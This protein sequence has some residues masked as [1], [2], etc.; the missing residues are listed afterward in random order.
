MPYEITD[1]NSRVNFAGNKIAI[2][3]TK[4]YINK[5]PLYL[6]GEVDSRTNLNIK[7]RSNNLAIESLSKIFLPNNLPILKGDIDILAT[8]TGNLKTPKPKVRAAIRN[9]TAKDKKNSDLL[10]EFTKGIIDLAGSIDEPQGKIELIRVNILPKELYELIKPQKLNILITP[11]EIEFHNN[12]DNITTDKILFSGK[13][14]NYRKNPLEGIIKYRGNIDSNKIYTVAKKYNKRIQASAKG[15]IKVE[16]T[17]RIKGK[18][19]NIKTSCYADRW[20]YVSFMVIRELLNHP[21]VA[22]IDINTDGKDIIINNFTLNK[23]TESKEKIISINGKIKDIERPNLN[24]IR[25]IIPKNM[26]ISI[27]NLINSKITLKSDLTLDGNI[28]K[29]T[30][31]GNLDIADIDIPEYKIKSRINNIIFE[32]NNTKILMNNLMIGK[33]QFDI[34][35]DIQPRFDKIITITNLN[36]K[37]KYLDLDEFS[38]N[39]GSINT[40]PIYPGIEIPIR[41]IKGNAE[42]KTFKISGLQGDNIT[43]N[44]SI[45]KNILKIDNIKG[46][47]YG[48]ALR[49]KTEYNFLKTSSLSEIAG[50]NAQLNPLFYALTGKTDGTTGIIDYKLKLSTIGTKKYQQLKTGKGY[51]EYTAT[52]GTMGTLGQ[53]EHFLYAQNLISDSIFKTSLYKIA[54]AIKPQN[55]GLYTISKGN[56]EINNGISR[57]KS[58]T[59]EG[60]NMSLYI[61]GKINILN[62][63]ADIKIYGR[64]SQEVENAL[65][66]LSTQTSKTIL[67]NSSQTSIGN[68]FYNDYNTQLPQ[69]ITDAI[70]PLNP[71]TGISSRPFEVVI[72][73]TPTNI[74]AVKSFK[75]IVKTTQA[76]TPNTRMIEQKQPEEKIPEPQKN[77][78]PQNQNKTPNFMDALPDYIN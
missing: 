58:L 8:I 20:N 17:A 25:I 24:K 55:T 11:K 34:S 2:T 74:K 14:S 31:Q 62:D 64:I 1:I 61:T 67:T 50:K 15:E 36:L 40:N 9:F 4:M 39:F 70:P 48:G 3:P 56:M 10:I 65:G 35:A 32:Q 42:I 29:P 76:P 54:K 53:F 18:N 16:G 21:S 51:L 33:S 46:A 41:A 72:Q 5:T 47:A 73:G 38:E 66:V 23:N 75:W 12:E 27:A 37:S 57:I 77:I 71:N 13:I 52:R 6:E 26:T 44:L 69:T 30:I 49:G 68:L 60:P 28:E 63:S 59:V 78:T 45:D 22:N 7:I 43:G 19:A